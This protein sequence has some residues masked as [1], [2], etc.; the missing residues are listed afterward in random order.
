MPTRVK[1]CG[2]T[3]PQDGQAAAAAGA[4]AIGLVFHPASPRYVSI[5]QA[6]AIVAALPPLVCVVGL[7]V[8][9]AAQTI[10]AVLREVPLDLLQFHGNEPPQ[11]CR[12]HG[13]RYLKA[14]H[15]R[16]DVDLARAAASY[17]DAAGL[18]LD[19][20][21]PGVPGGS[22]QVFDWA[23]VPAAWPRPLLLAGGL[24]AGNVAQA[25]ARLRP[26]AVDVSSGVETAPGIKDA[27]RIGAFMQ[28]VRQV[29]ADHG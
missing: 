20:F 19:A 7:F 10:D 28:A 11:A 4:H 18:L 15:V 23:A 2:I 9:A 12:R 14:L 17:E 24:D 13:R 16:P 29:D 27:A 26:W 6:R 3:R 1:I 22:G 21:V 5:E 8:D 25:V